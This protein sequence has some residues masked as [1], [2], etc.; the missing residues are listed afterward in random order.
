MNV[1]LEELSL[2]NFNTSGKNAHLFTDKTTS[3]TCIMLSGKGRC[4][5]DSASG[6]LSV[7]VE[8]GLAMDE[9]M[10]VLK[11]YDNEKREED[12]ATLGNRQKEN[13]VKDDALQRAR[14]IAAIKL[15]LTEQAYQCAYLQEQI[16]QRNT[17]LKRLHKALEGEQQALVKLADSRVKWGA[18]SFVCPTCKRVHEPTHVEA[19][20]QKMVKVFEKDKTDKRRIIKKKM[21]AL[22]YA[23][24]QLEQVNAEDAQH[25]RIYK[26]NRSILSAALK[27]L[28]VVKVNRL[29]DFGRQLSE[30]GL[31]TSD[32]GFRMS[33][34]RY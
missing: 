3:D 22:R 4:A 16:I 29:S 12:D 23:I 6:V 28:E 27:T 20:K 21:K 13:D 15:Q 32:I 18:E 33:D 26:S 17:E 2:D 10:N 1:I 31:G 34:F 7:A 24:K 5:S 30:V 11:R 9:Q 14:N 8:G 19:M 25:L